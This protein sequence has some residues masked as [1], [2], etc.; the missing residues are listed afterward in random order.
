MLDLHNNA[1]IGAACARTYRLAREKEKGRGEM[2]GKKKERRR[3]KKRESTTEGSLIPG[4]ALQFDTISCPL[5]ITST[6]SRRRW[7][8]AHN[9]QVDPRF[10]GDPFFPHPAILRL[11]ITA[12]G[13]FIG[14]FPMRQNPPRSSRCVEM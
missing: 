5:S 4:P 12:D 14:N 11:V 13:V 2:G 1:W 8:C 7:S 3:E 6:G 10:I 9:H